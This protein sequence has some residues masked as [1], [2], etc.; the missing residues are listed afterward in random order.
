MRRISDPTAHYYRTLGFSAHNGVNMI[1]LK[2]TPPLIPFVAI[3]TRLASAQPPTEGGGMGGMGGMGGA[4]C[5]QGQNE[6]DYDAP[7]LKTA[8]CRGQIG[9][10]ADDNLIFG[11]FEAGFSVDQTTRFFGCTNDL[12]LPGGIDTLNAERMVHAQAAL[13]HC[14]DGVSIMNACGGHANPFHYHERMTCLYNNDDP[15]GHSTTSGTMLDGHKIYGTWEHYPSRV[16][17]LLDAC[18][19]HFGVTPDSGGSVV[20][21]YHVAF[22][23]PFLASCFGPAVEN[24]AEVMVTLAACRAHHSSCGDNDE[25]DITIWDETQ[26]V[27]KTITYDPDCP[28]WDGN[29]SNVGSVPLPFELATQSPSPPTT[30]PPPTVALPTAAP[31]TA[32]PSPPTTTSP[33]RPPT[34]RKN[35][36]L[37]MPDDLQFLW[38]EAPPRT[39]RRRFTSSLVPNI[40]RIRDEGT[41]FEK[42]YVAGPKCAPSRFNII[43][44]RYCSRSVHARATSGSGEGRTTVQV[45]QCKIDGTDLAGTMP[46]VLRDSG[47]NTIMAGKWHL[48][49]RGGGSGSPWSNYSAVVEHVRSSGFTT[50]VAVFSDN[51]SGDLQFGHNLEW[52]AAEA[53]AAITSA[54]AAAAPFFLYFTPTAPHAPSVYNSLMEFTDR[55]TPAGVL[56][57]SPDSGFAMNRT[58]IIAAADLESNPTSAAGDIYLDQCVGSLLGKL[59]ELSV[60]DETLVVFVMD[61]GQAAKDTLYE[62]GTRVAMMARLPGHIPASTQVAVSV[63]NLDFAPTFFDVARVGASPYPI[64]GLSWWMAAAGAPSVQLA[65]RVCLVSEIDTDRAVVCSRLG[66]YKYVSKQ[67]S[68]AGSRAYPFSNDSTQLYY[69]PNDGTEQNSLVNDTN[70][71]SSLATLTAYIRCHDQDTAPLNPSP[72]NAEQNL[73]GG[74]GGS[75]STLSSTVVGSSTLPATVIGSSTFAPGTRRTPAPTI[76]GHSCAGVM[77]PSVRIVGGTF[78]LNSTSGGRIRINGVNIVRV[79]QQIHRRANIPPPQTPSPTQASVPLPQLRKIGNNLVIQNGGPILFNGFDVMSSIASLSPV[80]VTDG[81]PPTGSAGPNRP[82]FVGRNGDDLVLRASNGMVLVNGIDIVSRVAT[83][84]QIYPR[85]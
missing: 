80:E 41:V 5:Q 67:S 19:G 76:C 70:H 57:T 60:L 53:N 79:L 26:N 6:V 13:G 35:I 82:V 69:L 55:D 84:E 71:A 52:M 68:E 44:G 32:A 9:T 65:N 73:P 40:N 81:P 51:L 64:D 17:P 27:T 43:T 36:V 58:E 42:A 34:D 22:E 56:A 62:G 1:L 50:P 77:A 20:Y 30:A 45:P 3:V 8:P 4:S 23:P 39:D 7:G 47:Y 74:Q 83:L 16:R 33:T 12:E 48:M 72:C 37:I 11:P 61:H 28:C 66:G 78:E 85:P 46:T 2:L 31:V 29:N 15:S 49:P 24:G 14:N 38:P 21:H 75:Q 10:A 59:E 63:S 25:I 18:G 54:V